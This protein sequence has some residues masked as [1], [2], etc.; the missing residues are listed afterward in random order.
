M[1]L[2]PLVAAV[3]VS[4]VL[5]SAASAL[6][7]QYPYTDGGGTV[8][9]TATELTITGATLGSPA[10]TITISCPLVSYSPVYFPYYEEWTC[11]GGSLTAQSTNGKTS[12]R[13]SFTTGRFT[14]QE[15]TY[16]GVTTYYYALDVSFS[17]SQT[18]NGVSTAVLAEIIQTLAPLSSALNPSTGTIQSG[19]ID[20]NQ[21]YEPVYVADTGNNRIVQMADMLGSNWAALGKTGSGVNQ[22][23]APWGVA[24]DAA[25][26]IYVADSGNCRIVQMDNITGLNWKSYGTCGSGTGQF[27]TPKGIWIDSSG[28]Y[29]A[30]SGNNRIVF[31]SGITGTNFTTLGTLGSGQNQFN[32]P[33]GVTRDTAGKIYAADTGNT[34]IVRA[35]NMTGT[36]WTA[37]SSLFSIYTA[38]SGIAVDRTGKIYVSAAV[39]GFDG[40]IT[41]IDDMTGANPV[42]VDL[43]SPNY[44]YYLIETAAISVDPDGA[45]YA[46]DTAGDR[47]VRF[48]DM[49]NNGVLILGNH[50]IPGIFSHPEGVF[51]VPNSKKAA[52]TSVSSSSLTFPTELVGSPSPIQSTTL[53]NIGAAPLTLTGVSTS[54][55]DFL[56]TNNCPRTLL[57]GHSC[58][59]SVYFR[60]A[61]GGLL[62]DS[63]SFAISKRAVKVSLTGSGALVTLS[64]GYLVLY[65]GES[66]V[67][68]ITNPLTTPAGIVS[69][70]ATTPF[71]QVS[72]T[73][74][75]TLAP[76]ASCTYTVG[77]LYGGYVVLGDVNV[78]DGS[79]TVQYVGVTGE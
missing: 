67:V 18:I 40:A 16:R 70:S 55:P 33:S 29:V 79:G 3:V 34:R 49:T 46:T 52:V 15:Q 60:P 44:L 77:W 42:S 62:K 13:G 32:D 24:V 71:F 61:T 28:I 26:K 72:S 20:V 69:I 63:L 50:G 10:G 30:D 73:C 25:G 53:S 54:T 35:D 41:R 74:G 57:T 65:D 51:V 38:P 19:T 75:A 47:V 4:L 2:F 45:V 27:S 22:F 66:G 5:G 7:T 9:A 37:L 78:T 64:P 23:S 31:M 59:G 43:G 56:A 58:S 36:N 68:T 39:F 48:F 11:I 1:K 17:G 6:A 21:Q 8:S 76:G 14:L 12:I